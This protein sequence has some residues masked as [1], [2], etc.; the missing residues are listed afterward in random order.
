MALRYDVRVFNK[1][2]KVVTKKR[3][4]TPRLAFRFAKEK[5][6]S[7]RAVKVTKVE[8]APAFRIRTGWGKRDHD[9]YQMA[10]KPVS[11]V[12]IHT[13]V[14]P[15]L[16]PD[17]TVEEEKE[18]MRNVDNIAFG[19]GFNGFSYSMGVFA[20]GRVYE[21][22]GFGVVE[23]ATGGFNTT[24]DSIATIGNTDAFNPTTKQIEAIV[25]T[26]RWGQDNGYFVH[27]GL[28]VRGHREV[29]AKACP[30]QFFTNAILEE[31]EDR[32]G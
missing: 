6:Q 5:F 22:R 32:V 11:T 23:A 16:P 27:N 24:S 28:Q 12:F 18:Q 26:I 14:T 20:S 13:S 3:F 4:K 8:V 10:P 1:D 25:Q 30:G 9:D 17:A 2:G 7:R 19:R 29:A 21:G 31:I 15:Q